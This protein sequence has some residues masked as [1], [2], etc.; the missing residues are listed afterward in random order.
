MLSTFSCT[1]WMVGHLDAFFGNVSLAP[2]TFFNW[3]YFLF[4]CWVV[5]V[6]YMF[7]I[8]TPF[9]IYDLQIFS[10][11]GRFFFFILLIVSLSIQKLWCSVT[12]L[13]LLL[14]WNP[15][16][17][18]HDWCQG[19]YLHFFLGVLWFHVLCLSLYSILSWF[20]YVV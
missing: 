12:C 7:W 13:F 17:H 19:A 16:N 20:L 15:K 5:W 8:L 2:L 6:L 14:V 11:F 9:Q 3:I 10:P 18:F 1:I 4:C